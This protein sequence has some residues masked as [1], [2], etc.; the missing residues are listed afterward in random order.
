MQPDTLVAIWTDAALNQWVVS[1]NRN[2]SETWADFDGRWH[3]VLDIQQRAHPPTLGPADVLAAAWTPADEETP[4]QVVSAIR[5]PTEEWDDFEAEWQQA[6]D[7]RLAEFPP[8]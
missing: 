8:S 1:R 7:A 4:Q 3:K 5:G 2:P 6:L